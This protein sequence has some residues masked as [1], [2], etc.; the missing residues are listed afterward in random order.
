MM[1]T[2]FGLVKEGMALFAVTWKPF[3]MN[4]CR[5]GRM[6]DLMPSCRYSGSNP[7]THTTT[8][9]C[10]GTTYSLEW[11]VNWDCESGTWC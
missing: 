11:R 9:G 3:C 4:D 10:L 7:S 6:P 8:V 5:V 2:L 1:D